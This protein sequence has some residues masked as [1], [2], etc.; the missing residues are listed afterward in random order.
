MDISELENK[1]GYRFLS[2]RLCQQAMR[3]RSYINEQ[4]E[5]GLEDNERLEF[6]GDAVLSL[7]VS[8]LLMS[9]YPE[10]QEGALSKIRASLVNDQSLAVRA[11]SLF[12]GSFILLGRGEEMTQGRDKDSILAGAFEALMGAIYLD[13]GLDAALALATRCFSGDIRKLNLSDI[14]QDHKSSLQEYTQAVYKTSPVYEIIGSY[15]PDHEKKFR[16]SVT[17]GDI[18]AEGT[19]SSKQAAQQMAA[20]EALKRIQSSTENE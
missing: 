20:Q 19:G 6:L 5:S 18:V 12:L 3:H 11:R 16:Y 9:S 13:G 14:I 2:P 17:A 15:G 4:T 8:H 10:L 7:C 1:I